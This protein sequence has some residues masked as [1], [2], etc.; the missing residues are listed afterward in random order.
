MDSRKKAIWVSS[1]LMPSRL[2][3]VDFAS[4][5]DGARDTGRPLW[6]LIHFRSRPIFFL[7]GNRPSP[8]YACRLPAASVCWM[9]IAFAL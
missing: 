5:L 1:I 4:K 9:A 6:V 8:K 3:R 7:G 2:R